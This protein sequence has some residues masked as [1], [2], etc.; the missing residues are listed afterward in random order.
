MR[1]LLLAVAV[2]GAGA[3]GCSPG[4]A[5]VPAPDIEARR[6]GW[7]QWKEARDELM[8]S[9]DSPILPENRA[10]FAGLPYFD[11]DTTLVLGLRLRPIPVAD[12]TYLATTG[13]PPRPYVSAGAIRF[14]AGGRSAVE[15][16][17]FFE[18]DEM[19][20]LLAAAR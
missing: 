13:G 14:D 11:S 18:L 15:I 17:A 16:A 4:P 2:A 6:A 9:A 5:P 7:V 12:T 8:R 3:T 19:A 10:A 20:A 1:R